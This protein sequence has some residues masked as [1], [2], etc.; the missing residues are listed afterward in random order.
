MRAKANPSYIPP[1]SNGNSKVF[2]AFVVGSNPTGGAI[3]PITPTG[4]ESGLRI[5]K[6][7]VQIPCRVPG[8]ICVLLKVYHSRGAGHHSKLPTSSLI[9]ESRAMVA[10]RAV[11]P[12][13]NGIVGSSPTSLTTQRSEVGAIS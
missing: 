11:T 13:P 4:R 9:W 7:W 10:Q 12:W 2:E 6:V 5:R 8:H 1:W 3:C